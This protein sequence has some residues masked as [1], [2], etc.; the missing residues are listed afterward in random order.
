MTK[1]VLCGK[2]AITTAAHIPVCMEHYNKYAE[3]GKQY[4]SYRPFYEKLLKADNE[5][6]ANIQHQEEHDVETLSDRDIY[7]GVE[8][9]S[10]EDVRSIL[11]QI[12]CQIRDDKF[13]YPVPE[14]VFLPYSL[15]K[16]LKTYTEDNC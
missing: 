12:I 13:V 1:C 15:W 10:E 2:E 9:L 3:E 6:K 4:P 7:L 11:R 14:K 16:V 8:L 5:R